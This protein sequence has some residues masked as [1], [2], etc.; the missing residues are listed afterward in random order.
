MGLIFSFPDEVQGKSLDLLFF[1]HDASSCA[2]AASRVPFLS[3]F[4]EQFIGW[5]VDE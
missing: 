3:S 1:V 2:L 4:E 5:N